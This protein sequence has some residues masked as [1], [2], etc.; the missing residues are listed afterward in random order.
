MRVSIIIDSKRCSDMFFLVI[1]TPNPTKPSEAKEG[2]IK[3][4]KWV[5]DLK[6]TNKVKCFYPRIG[7]GSIVIFDISS[8][9]EL[10]ELLTQWANIIPV[11]FD[12]YPLAD[13]DSAEKLLN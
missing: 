6:S 13:P 7:R 3:F 1:S 8:N 2:R 5:S 4:R 11:S 9:N 12:I 10:H